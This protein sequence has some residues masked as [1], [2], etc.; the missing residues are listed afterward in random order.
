MNIKAEKINVLQQIINSDDVN[1]TKDIKALINN[2]EMDWFDGLSKRQQNDVT[3][4]LKQLDNGISFS[5][6]EAKI[7]FGYK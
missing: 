7:K 1:L 3:K 2:R 5:Q 4:G 6:E